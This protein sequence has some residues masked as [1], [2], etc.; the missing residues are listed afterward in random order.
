VTRCTSCGQ[1]NASDSRFCS[2]CGGLLAHTLF[3]EERKV[4]TV[5][6]CDLVDFTS[7][8]ERLDPEDV[9]ALQAPYYRHVRAELEHH[10]GTVEK[11][12]G[13]A[14]MALFG[15]PAAHEDDPERAVRAALAI[16]DWVTEQ[17]DLRVRIAVTTGEA[18][19]HLEAQP[20]TGEGMAAGDVVNTAARL[21]A[22]APENG[23]LTD[24][25]T[26]RATEE[27]IEYRGA[28]RVSVKGK[29]EPVA[30]WEAVRALVPIRPMRKP[31][32]PFVGRR[33]EQAVLRDAFAT[34]L[35]GDSTQLVTI[36]GVPGIGK[37]RLV[38][39]LR[40]AV[41][42]EYASVTWLQGR[43]LPYGAG[44][45]MWALGEI[46]KAHAS[47]LESDGD[48]DAD[49]KLRR[50]V[51][52][53]VGDGTEA[54]WVHAHLRP[55]VMPSGA[56]EVGDRRAEAF[57]AWRRFFEALAAQRP[58]VLVLEDVH[59]ADD[60]LLD[61]VEYLVEW[62]TDAPLFVLATA[63]PELLDR[64][65][66]W[67]SSRPDLKAVMLA[68]L[69]DEETTRLLAS[70]LERPLLEAEIQA[71]LLTQAAGNPLYAEEYVRL[72]AAH[73]DNVGPG[74]APDTVQG[75]IA[76]RI[77]GLSVE[78]KTLLQDAAVLG[79]VF[80]SGG[81]GVLAGRDRWAVESRLLALERSELLQR[82]RQSA[83]AGETQ[84]AFLHDL[85]RD[86][87]YGEIPHA[88]RS[89]KHL[90][91]A[92]WIDSLSRPEDHAELLAHHYVSALDYAPV[93]SGT[94]AGLT[95][96]ARFALRDAGDRAFSLNAFAQAAR[97]YSDTLALW[98]S[99]DPE[100]P[101]LLFQYASALHVAGDAAQEEMLEEARDAL[102]A[103]SDIE[104]AAE[105]E[106]QLAAMWWYRGRGDLADQSARRAV[107][108]VRDR[109]PSAAKV[110]SL[111]ALARLRMLA[112][113]SK[114]AIQVG[115]E[116][117][118][119]ATALGL[120]ELRADL[121]VTVGTASWHAGDPAGESDLEQGLDLA[122]TH[123]ALRVAGRAYNNLAGVMAAKGDF[124]RRV[125][126]VAEAL[127][128]AEQLGEAS[129][130]RHLQAQTFHGLSDR[131]QWDEAL[132]VADEFI[133]EC[134][135]GSP[136]VSESNVRWGRA[137]IHL[138]RGD[139]EA[140]LTGW[141]FSLAIARRSEIP[142][143]VVSS[144]AFGACLYLQLGRLAE[145]QA[146]ADEILAYDAD[147]VAVHGL[148]L[149]WVANR[150]GRGA[151]LRAKF[152]AA[153]PFRPWFRSI[154][155]LLLAGDL[156]KVADLAREWGMYAIEAEARLSA[157][158]DLTELGRYEEADEQLERALAFYR[159]VGATRYIQEAQA[160]AAM[161][162]HD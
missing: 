67:N 99:D 117:L 147:E 53:T 20:L 39:E 89:D 40:R 56:G 150:I 96:Q 113:D 15:A 9:R 122:L 1:E 26:Y 36:V 34:A 43:S 136:H 76:A 73:Q 30:V 18:L 127:R 38:Q 95:E 33:H 118:T 139:E 137:Y 86:V 80:W 52:N 50:T 138:A 51:S 72:L 109:P 25:A 120:H 103:V 154:A 133:A 81:V 19:I 3:R 144:L 106:A 27:V 134:E 159:T 123:G 148:G 8:A 156:A 91:A 141:E 160:M 98:P 70:L 5:I 101:R 46:V 92:E 83:V 102:L 155:D 100:R 65:P 149:A 121:L 145:A 87:A 158:R 157:A 49:E 35:A 116:A 16:R 54:T 129:V 37:S 88:E 55:L 69:S 14:V 4:V 10:G 104:T 17:G 22:A 61:F 135:S 62:A 142:D 59:W 42:G 31:R 108:L 58:V 64:R 48:E 153:R 2:R 128:L 79:K 105:A 143:D 63:R 13:D 130:L 161:G 131:G 41:E 60:A 71:T 47:I 115:G 45:T 6:F 29:V 78:Q 152:D 28:K 32:A 94:R 119:I 93:D 151:Q 68:P 107:S 24:E 7:R 12:I 111:A 57:A 110:R 11:F 114:D 44:V 23:V 82:E 126:L 21:Q 77:D 85:I 66:G 124:T 112:Q 132:R 140:A 146:L 162:A 84:Y 90:R 75:I 97:L 74:R 125:E